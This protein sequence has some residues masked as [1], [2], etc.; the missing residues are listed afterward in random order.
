M[1][2]C[3]HMHV[4]TFMCVHVCG[5]MC[6]HACVHI[7]VCARVWVHVCTC[8]CVHVC[9]Y[10][11][12]HACVCMCVG[13]CVHVCGYMC[14]HGFQSELLASW[15]HPMLYNRAVKQRQDGGRGKHSLLLMVDRLRAQHLFVALF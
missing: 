4:C 9:G 2:V 15:T 7:H 8:M 5:Y 1:H 10:M 6:A 14:A 3:V 12:A 13:T 11:C